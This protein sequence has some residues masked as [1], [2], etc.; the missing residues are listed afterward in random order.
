MNKIKSTLG[1]IGLIALLV[2]GGKCLYELHDINIKKQ[3]VKTDYHRF[4]NISFGLLDAKKWRTQFASLAGK[5]VANNILNDALDELQ[6]Q[7]SKSDEGESNIF[8]RGKNYLINSFLE[9]NQ[10]RSRIPEFA[11]KLAGYLSKKENRLA[12]TGFLDEHV[13]DLI[14]LDLTNPKAKRSV[15]QM[16]M[17]KHD[18][19]DEEY[20]KTKLLNRI[21]ELE[22]LSTNNLSILLGCFVGAFLIW[23]L[24]PAMDRNAIHFNLVA[25]FCLI[26]LAGGLLFP[27]IDID[28]KIDQMNIEIMGSELEFEQQSV[29]FQSKSILDVVE[30]LIE[31][32]KMTSVL[33][34]FLILLFSAIFPLTKILLSSFVSFSKKKVLHPIVDFFVY[35]SGKWSMADVFV[36]AI[37]MA[38]IGFSSILTTQL[39]KIDDYSSNINVLATDKTNFQDGFVL[40]LAFVIGSMVLSVLLKKQRKKILDE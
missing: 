13:G 35:R 28:A 6:T 25:L 17:E 2:F 39:N 5:E 31:D 22:G 32:T 8:G 40:F 4:I 20:Y 3:Q 12:I 26:V 10:I 15:K 18:A 33:V 34:G 16:L 38:F 14:P 11:D 29:F 7:I 21:D 36:V 27:M 19:P 37:F 1:I 24:V 23:F 9:S 30:I